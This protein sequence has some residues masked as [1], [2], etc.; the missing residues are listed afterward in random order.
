M[1]PPDYTLRELRLNKSESEHRGVFGTT[2]VFAALG[3][4]PIIRTDISV[5][6]VL[7]NVL[8]RSSTQPFQSGKRLL[9]WTIGFQLDS[10]FFIALISA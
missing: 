5:R 1:K 3:N 6:T 2:D 7:L 10:P 9:N 4:E 8:G